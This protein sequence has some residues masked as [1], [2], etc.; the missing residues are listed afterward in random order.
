MGPR[1]CAGQLRRPRSREDRIRPGALRGP[2]APRRPRGGDA[3]APPR[4]A[5]G[6]RRRGPDAGVARRRLHHRPDHHRRRR[7]DDRA[8]RISGK[9]N[10]TVS[11]RE[12]RRAPKQSRSDGCAGARDCFAFARNDTVEL[13]GRNDDVTDF[14]SG[15]LVEPRCRPGARPKSSANSP[16]LSTAEPSPQTPPG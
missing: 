14:D 9:S 1:Q 16:S 13:A 8:V 2:A 15:R 4:R 11:L 12:A 5:R 7:H 3:A 6:H 10:P